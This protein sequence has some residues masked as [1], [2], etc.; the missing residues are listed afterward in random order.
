MPAKRLRTFVCY[1]YAPP[2]PAKR[3]RVDAVE[4]GTGEPYPA[5]AMPASLLKRQTIYNVFTRRHAVLTFRDNL[6]TGKV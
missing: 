4:W 5:D 2:F 3:R 6:A 1:Q